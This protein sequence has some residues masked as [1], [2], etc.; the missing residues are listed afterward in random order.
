MRKK[1]RREKEERQQPKWQRH[2]PLATW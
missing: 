1:R 2:E